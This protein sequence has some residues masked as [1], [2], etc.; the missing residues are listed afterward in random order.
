MLK[1]VLVVAGLF[2]FS[3]THG[4]TVVSEA[5]LSFIDRAY[6]FEKSH[7]PI[8][9]SKKTIVLD[10]RSFFD[11]QVSRLP[12][13]TH[14]DPVE[15]NI[16]G[17]YGSSLEK[18]AAS[19]TRRL[20]L[21][22]INPFSHVVVVGYGP[23]GKGM[24]GNVAF[25]LV[26]LGVERVQIGVMDNFRNLL[27]AKPPKQQ[28]N[29]RQWEP[30]LMTSIICSPLAEQQAYVIDVSEKTAYT[31]R[32]TKNMVRLKIPWRRFVNDED[33]SASP[34]VISALRE[35]KVKS[36]S[37]LMIRGLQAP[38]AAF[39]LLRLGYNHVCVSQ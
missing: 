5:D 17:S 23:K 34:Q 10:A 32:S 7:R 16:V 13:A 15:F 26:A 12:G 9:I 4:P 29:Q 36:N 33:F 8:Q 27:T 35:Y 28:E 21:M 14:V 31:P 18:K 19:L 39:S 11:Y 30:R 25:T 24:E 2:L 6:K 38:L 37:F 20:A 22:G 3:C 1:V